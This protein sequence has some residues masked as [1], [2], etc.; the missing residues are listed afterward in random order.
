MNESINQ[1]INQLQCIVNQLSGLLPNSAAGGSVLQSVSQSIEHS[2]I[3][4]HAETVNQ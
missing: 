2:L 4:K 3:V 1:S